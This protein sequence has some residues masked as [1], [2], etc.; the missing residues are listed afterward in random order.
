MFFNF[1]YNTIII[2]IELSVFH[3][4]DKK[5]G[6]IIYPFVGFCGKNLTT[7]YVVQ[8]IIVGWLTSFQDYLNL[9]LG[10]RC[11]LSSVS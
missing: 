4:I 11:L 5:C 10:C 7:I 9:H 3:Y 2:V 1:L 8:W 6:R